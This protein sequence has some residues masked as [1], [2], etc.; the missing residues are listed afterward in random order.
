MSSRPVVLST[1]RPHRRLRLNVAKQSRTLDCHPHPQPSH[2][3]ASVPGA[4]SQLRA[5]LTSSCSGRNFRLAPF[6]SSHPRSSPSS[7]LLAPPSKPVQNPVTPLPSAAVLGHAPPSPA[8]TVPRS[9]SPF[10][11]HQSQ[12]WGFED[13]NLDYIT[14]QF[15]Y[16]QW[17]LRVCRTKPKLLP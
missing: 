4:P 10:S 11:T 5:L 16:L 12:E 15:K 14:S 3:P 13:V 8:W 17:L 2:G 1:C 6:C 7:V 9:S